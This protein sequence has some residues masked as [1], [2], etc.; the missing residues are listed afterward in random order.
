MAQ[1][2]FYLSC[3]PFPH[4]SV[5]VCHPLSYPLLSL[6]SSSSSSSLSLVTMTAGEFEFTGS[7]L[8]YEIFKY[9]NVHLSQR[10]DT[11]MGKIMDVLEYFHRFHSESLVGEQVLQQCKSIKCA[12][13]YSLSPRV[14]RT[15]SVYTFRSSFKNHSELLNRFS[16]IHTVTLIIQELK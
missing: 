4:L 7:H 13:I 8:K 9:R 2:I 16:R 5:T 11:K 6:F 14:Y 3:A 15:L 12:K 10:R 1:L